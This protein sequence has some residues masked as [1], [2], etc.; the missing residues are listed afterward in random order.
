[1][2]IDWLTE[3][4]GNPVCLATRSAV[5][6]RVP[7]S[8]VGIVG[9]GHQVHGGPDDARAVAGQHHRTVHLAQ[10]AQA[11]GGELDVERE[12]ATGAHRLD[13]LVVPQHDQRPGAPA[14]D[15]LQAVAQRGAGRHQRQ[16]GAHRVAGAH[17]AGPHGI[18]A[19]RGRPLGFALDRHA[20]S[21]RTWG[22]P[23]PWR[24]ASQSVE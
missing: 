4:T 16:R 13:D 8:S 12:P 18:G 14:Q 10:F 23:V 5:R 7:D 17:R 21:L 6:W 20:H 2:R 3:M 22:E 15:A 24:A 11:G 19:G 9:V 1:M